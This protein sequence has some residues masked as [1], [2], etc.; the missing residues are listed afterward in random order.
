MVLA[1]ISSVPTTKLTG[2]LTVPDPAIAN[3]STPG[4]LLVNGGFD[5]VDALGQPTFAPWIRPGAGGGTFSSTDCQLGTHCLYVLDPLFVFPFP[6]STILLSFTPLSLT[7]PSQP[8]PS[9]TKLTLP[10][11][12][13]RR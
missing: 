7:S 8:R 1:T 3:C 6:F 11:L 10:Q 4:D 12:P 2:T 5:A 13:P 9:P